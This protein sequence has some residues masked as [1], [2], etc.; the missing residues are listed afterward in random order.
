MSLMLTTQ[1][2]FSGICICGH[3][4]YQ[5]HGSCIARQEVV[6]LVKSGTFFGECEHFGCNEWWE[7]CPDCYGYIDKDDPLKGEKVAERKSRV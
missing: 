6:D 7:P 3:S 2:V 1:H 5:H 4:A